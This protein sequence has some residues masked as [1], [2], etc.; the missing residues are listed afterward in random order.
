MYSIDCHLVSQ[1]TLFPTFTFPA[2]AA[3]LSSGFA[4]RNFAIK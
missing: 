4:L 1:F 2:T 3:K